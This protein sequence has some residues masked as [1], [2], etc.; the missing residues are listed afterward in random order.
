MR[1][2]LLFALLCLAQPALAKTY[3]CRDSDGQLHFSDNLQ[4]LPEECL[5]KEQVVKPG[6]IDN[7]QYV[8]E[9]KLPAESNE[10]FRRAVRQ[11]ERE[12]RLRNQAANQFRQQTEGLRQRYLDI[13]EEMRRARRIWDDRSRQKLKQLK[14]DLANL[15]EEKQSLQ[16]E[17][18]DRRLK[19]EDQQ[20]IEV[21]LQDIE[22]E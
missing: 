8:P 15:L 14:V 17:L 7:L 9:T 11:V 22:D 10:E 4:G 21:I 3:S 13:K 18:T 12:E 2:V 16:Q 19:R 5:G 20:A 1:I 6:P